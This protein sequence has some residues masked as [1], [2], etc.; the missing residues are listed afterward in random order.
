MRVVA[1]AQAVPPS[2]GAEEGPRD[3]RRRRKL[4]AGGGGGLGAGAWNPARAVCGSPGGAPPSWRGCVTGKGRRS[5]RGRRRPPPH[6]GELFSGE[7]RATGGATGRQR[8]LGPG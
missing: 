7:G 3:L 6:G 2:P 1:P 5:T 4:R 8:G